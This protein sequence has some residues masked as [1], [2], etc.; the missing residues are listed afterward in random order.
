VP[1]AVRTA[2][3]S[4]VHYARVGTRRLRAALDL[5]GPVL[6]QDRRAGAFA[7]SLRRLRRAL[8]PLRDADVMLG[9]LEERSKQSRHAAAT[10]W[11]VGQFARRRES[12][13][14]RASSR[15]PTREVLKGLNQWHHLGR[16]LPEQGP[17][18]RS[19]AVWTLPRQLRSFVARADRLCRHRLG[20]G[21]QTNDEHAGSQD[22]VHALRIDGKLLRYTLELAKPIGLDVPRRLLSKFK[23]LQ[24][25]LGLWHDYVVLG[26]ESLRVALDQEIA[27][28]TPR[29]YADIL[30]LARWC[31][32]RSERQLD[33]FARL[34]EANGKTIESQVLEVTRPQRQA[35]PADAPASVGAGRSDSQTIVPIPQTQRE[36]PA[37][38]VVES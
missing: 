4:A 13:R 8:G 33:R 28:H 18:V 27:L 20:P 7:R 32:R 31:W 19:L 35:L 30:D 36:S 29:M 5:L 15:A 26:E 11:L 12:L 38:V 3:R 17:Q 21:S 23:Q 24:D 14:S 9:H 34:W 1:L 10:E 16:R 6:P 2:D 25:A 37:P 22:D